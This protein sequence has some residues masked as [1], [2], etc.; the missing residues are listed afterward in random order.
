M[1]QD[2]IT[3]LTSSLNS[4]IQTL[5]ILSQELNKQTLITKQLENERLDISKKNDDLKK[6]EQAVEGKY[7]L[8]ESEKAYTELKSKE[9]QRTEE[10]IGKQKGQW[11][12]KLKELDT[13]EETVKQQEEQVK[14]SLQDLE[15]KKKE[16]GILEQKE[17]NL[18]R[19][20]E[21]MKKEIA[22]DRDRKELLQAKE[23]II[24]QKE[25]RLQRLATV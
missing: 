8:I 10:M 1:N 9:N 6:R 12:D 21:L 7:Q 16:L 18:I 22:I 25:A 2:F 24:E 5:Q 15:N 20:E 11:I 3:S 13:R 4:L 23:K 14:E 17:E 19:R